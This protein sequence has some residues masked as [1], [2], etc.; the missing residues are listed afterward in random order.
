MVLR[1]PLLSEKAIALIEKENKLVFVVDTHA[2]K[3]QIKEEV[4]KTY[5]VKVED[6]NTVMTQKGE[7]RAFV[8]LSKDNKASDLATKLGII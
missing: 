4:E 2:S 1:H 6:V 8:K 5:S 7:K 3:S